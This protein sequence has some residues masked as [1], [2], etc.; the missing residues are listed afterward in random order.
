MALLSL[1]YGFQRLH[2]SEVTRVDELSLLSFFMRLT[3]GAAA[4]HQGVIGFGP[5][6]RD[7]L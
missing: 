2:L 5:D 3:D 1:R 4:D 6:Q 7:S